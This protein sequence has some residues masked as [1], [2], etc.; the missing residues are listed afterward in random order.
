M[1]IKTKNTLHNLSTSWLTY[2]W[3]IL[4]FISG[5][6]PSHHT[7]LLYARGRQF[8]K[9]EP[10]PLWARNFK[11]GP[12]TRLLPSGDENR[13]KS[14]IRMFIQPFPKTLSYGYHR[15]RCP[16]I[17]I[18]SRDLQVRLYNEQQLSRG[19]IYSDIKRC[20]KLSSIHKNIE[21][22]MRKVYISYVL[23]P[24]TH[25]VSIAPVRGQRRNVVAS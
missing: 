22:C 4:S 17:W 1:S 8:W 23:R 24:I 25:D 16:E 9:S 11:D 10:V 14:F 15:K 5:K 6:T 3:V 20:P 19:M 7:K 13:I 21:Y 2:L 12:K 18:K